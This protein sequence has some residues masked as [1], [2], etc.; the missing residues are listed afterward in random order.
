MAALG[1]TGCDVI[2]RIEAP[3]L[4]LLPSWTAV[5]ETKTIGED[6]KP[7]QAQTAPARRARAARGV[8]SPGRRPEL[9]PALEEAF[10]LHALRWEGRPDGSGFVH[11][12]RHAVPPG[13]RPAGWPSW[14]S[15]ASSRYAR[16]PGDRLPLLLRPR[17]LH[18]RPPARVRPGA[19]ALFARAR[20]HAGR[21][22][23]RI[24][25]GADP[26]RVPR[27]RRALQ[28]RAGGPVRAALPGPRPRLGCARSGAARGRARRH[29]PAHAAQALAPAAPLLLRPSCPGAGWR[30]APGTAS[31][32]ERPATRRALRGPGAR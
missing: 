28:A 16:R 29:S 2:E 31:S 23:G 9:E 3:V 17:G 6:A 19:F 18:V 12:D 11:A 30:R 10:R 13:R 4:E 15:R 8:R 14:T 21:A 22:P 25:R 26:R 24:R 7:A 20:Q 1:R 27:R 5:Y 32:R